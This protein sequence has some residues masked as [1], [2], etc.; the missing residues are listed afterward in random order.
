MAKFESF[1]YFVVNNSQ[2][3]RVAVLISIRLNIL[4]VIIS[5]I[6]RIIKII[7]KKQ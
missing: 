2:I 6:I 4:I 7:K 1:V 5:I 3:D